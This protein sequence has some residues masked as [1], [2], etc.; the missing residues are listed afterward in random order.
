MTAAADVELDELTLILRRSRAP[1]LNVCCPRCDVAAMGVS[2]YEFRRGNRTRPSSIASN[3]RSAGDS[4]STS[5][6][7]ARR[8][9]S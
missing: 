1:N 4:S 5:S 6:L 2:T 9:P 7:G 8:R 3:M